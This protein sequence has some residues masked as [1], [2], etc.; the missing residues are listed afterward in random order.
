MSRLL[1]GSASASDRTLACPSWL[2]L[3]HVER[4]GDDAARGTQI[5]GYVRDVLE[6]TDPAKA[7]EKVDAAHRPLCVLLDWSRLGSDLEAPLE[8]EG[9]YAIDVRARTARYLGSN[10]GRAYEAAARAQGAPLGPWEV[11]GSLDIAGRQRGRH[12]RLVVLDLKS[13]FR[14]VT[15]S[16]E[17]GQ[18]LFFAA[19]KLLLEEDVEEVEFRIAHARTSG[20]VWDG[21]RAVFSR[22]DVD[23]Y[24]DEYEEQLVQA[25]VARQLVAAGRTPDVA[26]GDH[27]RYCPAFDA[28]PAQT[29]LARRLL[30]ELASLEGRVD[31]MTIAEVGAAFEIANTRVKPLLEK[32][33][34]PLK[35]RI[36]RDGLAPFPDGKRCAKLSVYPEERFVQKNALALLEQLGAT[37]EQLAGCYASHEVRKVIVGNMPA[38]KA[39][40]KGRAA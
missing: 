26:A 11:P 32:V 15:P 3:P 4:H 20:D 19:A 40:R 34:K 17:N 36:D 14:D 21:D 13:G 12:E 39:A 30:P 16:A 7:L 5:H 35:E 31:A 28:C 25:E 8:T 33:L 18:G 22:L 29:A 24:L 37:K 6:G 23:T 2:A 10:V 27:C 38:P 1:N 9:A